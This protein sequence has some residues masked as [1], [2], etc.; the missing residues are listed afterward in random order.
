MFSIY[1]HGNLPTRIFSRFDCFQKRK[2]NIYKNR[3]KFKSL[4]Q[5]C[6]VLFKRSFSACLNVSQASAWPWPFPV[7]YGGLDGQTATRGCLSDERETPARDS[8]PVSH[9]TQRPPAALSDVSTC[10]SE[11]F[12]SKT[13][14]PLFEKT[15]KAETWLMM[16]LHQAKHIM[17]NVTVR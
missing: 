3:N 8:G 17:A 6:Q 16:C 13:G 9:F 10:T 7:T 5:S 14:H 1:D 2:H 11:E 15:S 12:C 4:S